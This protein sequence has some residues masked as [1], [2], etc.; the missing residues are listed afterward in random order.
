MTFQQ[1]DTAAAPDCNYRAGVNST[2]PVCLQLVLSCS[3]PP[4]P[5]K[6]SLIIQHGLLRESSRCENSDAVK[7]TQHTAAT[8]CAGAMMDGWIISMSILPAC[9]YLDQ[10][11][12]KCGAP[13]VRRTLTRR[14]LQRDRLYFTFTPL[15]SLI[16]SLSV[17]LLC[18][19]IVM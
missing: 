10:N 6:K 8:L 11:K 9:K 12:C 5:H 14:C 4:W 18:N 1:R 2:C 3:L 16:Q 15:V 13:S 19:P 17:T 7:L